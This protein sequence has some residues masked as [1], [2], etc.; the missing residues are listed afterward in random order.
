MPP[1]IELVEGPGE[2]EIA[3]VTPPT[4]PVPPVTLPTTPP[5]D[6]GAPPTPPPGGGGPGP[7]V[8]PPSGSGGGLAGG[9]GGGFSPGGGEGYLAAA[10]SGGGGGGF[11]GPG[12]H[13]KRLQAPKGDLVVYLSQVPYTGIGGT[14]LTILFLIAL[15]GL[16]A[17]LSYSIV[18]FKRTKEFVAR[19]FRFPS[20]NLFSVGSSGL[21]HSAA[22][23]FT[24]YVRD[25]YG[26]PQP[27]HAVPQFLN[28]MLV[29]AMAMPNQRIILKILRKKL[30][31]F[32]PLPKKDMPR[33]RLLFPMREILQAKI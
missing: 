8:S 2:T 24:P 1:V 19:L 15:F 3:V 27:S 31:Q 33:L 25:R 29:I 30:V 12:I 17:L 11:G 22:L 26:Y 9:G 14:I 18:Y 23:T 7:D 20:L 4:P 5:V 13:L 28:F 32:Q 6:G 21:N 10:S 16:S